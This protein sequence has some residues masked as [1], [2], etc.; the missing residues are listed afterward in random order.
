[1]A[2]GLL[3]FARGRPLGEKGLDWLKIHLVNLHGA[4]KK[5]SL[6]K[7]VQYADEHMEEILDSADNPL[8]VSTIRN[9]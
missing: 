7:R 4:K 9:R 5:A 6:Q 2:R 8:E 3:L 1:M